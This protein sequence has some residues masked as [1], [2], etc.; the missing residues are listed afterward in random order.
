MIRITFP[1]GN[2]KEFDAGITGAEI[3]KSIS[4]K[5][6]K[7]ALVVRVNDED[8]DLSRPITADAAVE[9]I[10]RD[11]ERA[12]E[13]IRHDTADDIAHQDAEIEPA[14]VN[15]HRRGALLG[16]EIVADQ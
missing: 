9:I 16:R 12:L 6:A 10:T 15:R 7:K 11:D 2:H 1:D 4:G 13:H 3:A 8:W 5:L 14:G